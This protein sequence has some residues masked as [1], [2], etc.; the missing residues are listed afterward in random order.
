MVEMPM[1]HCVACREEVEGDISLLSKNCNN[2][3]RNSF[4]YFMLKFQETSLITV[5]SVENP[6]FVEL[7]PQRIVG[8]VRWVLQ[9]AWSGV[10]GRGSFLDDLFSP[11]LLGGACSFAQL[12]NLLLVLQ[13]INNILQLESFLSS[14][15]QSP[16]LLN[17]DRSH[18]SF[19]MR[20]IC[21]V[22]YNISTVLT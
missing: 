4:D 19:P 18:L 1:L 2:N 22:R 20:M 21:G 8:I 14:A 7:P 10:S 17:F 5:T 11:F 3:V 16:H 12:I 9:R 6:Q 15:S 13:Y